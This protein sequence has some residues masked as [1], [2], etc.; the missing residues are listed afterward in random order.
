MMNQLEENHGD[1]LSIF[2]PPPSN[3]AI[4]RR[5]F[6]EY[7]AISQL[8]NYADLEFLI[9][10][11]SAGYMDLKRSTLKVKVRLTDA[12]E[13]PILKDENAM[14]CYLQQTAVGQTGTN[15]PYKAYIDTLLSTSA[16]D[17]V[18]LESQL[19]IKDTAGP[20]DPNVRGVVI[21]GS[22][23]EVNTQKKVESWN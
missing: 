3:T 2:T 16:N 13:L 7:R 6:I 23:S 15:Y 22:I 9:P 19:F 4:Q 8:S 5:E 10:P 21:P 12:Y 20:D 14:D 11:Q 1:E 17:K 18:E